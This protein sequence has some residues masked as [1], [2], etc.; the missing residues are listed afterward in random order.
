MQCTQ[1]NCSKKE[2]KII[3]CKTEKTKKIDI[4]LRFCCYNTKKMYNKK[5]KTVLMKIKNNINNIIMNN[6]K[7]KTQFLLFFLFT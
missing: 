1:I 3:N 2:I 6:K 4:K 7:N 5:Y